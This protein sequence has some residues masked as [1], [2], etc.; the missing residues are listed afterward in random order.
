MRRLL[1][2][3]LDHTALP[4]DLNFD[5]QD[6]VSVTGRIVASLSTDKAVRHRGGKS[7]AACWKGMGGMELRRTRRDSWCEF[8]RCRTERSFGGFRHHHPMNVNHHFLLLLR[9]FV[10]PVVA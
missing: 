3:Y 4:S 8:P 7:A 9:K 10:G 2:L 1:S 5:G 6:A